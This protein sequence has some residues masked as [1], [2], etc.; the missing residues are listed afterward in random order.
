[1]KHHTYSAK[2]VF[3]DDDILENSDDDLEKLTSW[4]YRQAEASFGEMKAEIYDNRTHQVIKNIQYI[5]PEE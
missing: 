3:E 2:I 4:V 5:P 1:M